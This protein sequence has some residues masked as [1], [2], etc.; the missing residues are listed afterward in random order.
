MY[1]QIASVE[2]AR[3]RQPQITGL[4]AHNDERAQNWRPPI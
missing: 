4:S 2:I 3:L 1:S